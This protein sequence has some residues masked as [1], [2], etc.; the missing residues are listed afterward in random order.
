MVVKKDVLLIE[1]GQK[2]YHRWE[3]VSEIVH[4]FNSPDRVDKAIF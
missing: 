1:G 4:T 2:E 3:R